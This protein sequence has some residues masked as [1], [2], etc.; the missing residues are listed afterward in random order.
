MLSAPLPQPK[1]VFHV[2]PFII[3]SPFLHQCS[4]EVQGLFCAGCFWWEAEKRKFPFSCYLPFLPP[5]C[6]TKLGNS[7]GLAAYSGKFIENIHFLPFQKTPAF[8]RWLPV[9]VISL[10][11]RDLPR[12]IL[13]SP[14]APAHVAI[15]ITADFCY[16]KKKKGEQQWKS[17]RSTSPGAAGTQPVCRRRFSCLY[18]TV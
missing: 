16:K 18:Q 6:T 8:D 7:W 2:F 10:S 12:F 15:F 4:W 17:L 3:F 13:S 11:K 5:L 9:K 14:F 1:G